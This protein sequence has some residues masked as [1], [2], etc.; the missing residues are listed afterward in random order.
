MTK[1]KLEDLV[2]L[3]KRRGFIYQGSEIYGGL[4]GVWDWGPLGVM[5]K[6]N[7]AN[8]WWEHFVRSRDDMYPL[9]SAILMPEKIWEASG[10]LAGFNDPMVVCSNC[11]AQLRADHIKD[12]KCPNCGKSGTL[13]NPRSFNMMLKTELGAVEGE[14]QVAYLRPETAQGIFTN[15]K[16]VVDS[17][18]PDL[19]FG[20]AQIG[21]SFRNEISPR[22]FIFRDRE[23]ELMEIEYFIEPK[24]DWQKLFDYWLAEQKEFLK[25]VGVDTTLIHEFEHPDEDRSHYS[26]KT[27][28]WEFEYPFGRKEL[29]GLAYRTDYDLQ[30]HLKNSGKNLVYQP[31]DGG[32]PFVPHVLEPTFGVERL[33]LA[34]LTS[35][36]TEDK[37][38]SEKRIVL[39]LPAH[40][41]PYRV[42]V[43]PLLKNKSE[44][45]KKA[46]TVY[47]TLK[48]E[49]GNVL[50]DDNGNIGKRYRRQDEIGTPHTITIDFQTLDDDTV[51]VRD[52]DTT[53]QTRTK[54]AEL[55]FA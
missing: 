8:V 14:G 52:R 31:K 5:L 38:A 13:S 18:S 1:V 10:H 44:L 50:W 3:A 46:R 12:D 30:A 42:A 26:K 25:H 36:Y 40:M 53:K 28:D 32:K 2:S 51:T 39:K 7:I 21:K 37:V 19:P 6:Q 45:T 20:I 22:D 49:L 34:V 4:A 17:F 9:D 48:K 41:A 15:F 54:I 35:A 55:S 43:F 23:L 29:T 16:N 27:I 47:E 11:H 33:V 24:A